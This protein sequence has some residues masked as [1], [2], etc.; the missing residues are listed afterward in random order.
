MPKA[1]P[2]YR[3]IAPFVIAAVISLAASPAGAA[4]AIPAALPAAAPEAVQN[5]IPTYVI[6]VGGDT[7]AEA[8]DRQYA[9]FPP[10]LQ[11][12]IPR[13]NISAYA[14][15]D[16]AAAAAQDNTDIIVLGGGTRIGGRVYPN[17][18]QMPGVLIEGKHHLRIFGMPGPIID[19]DAL[20]NS[21]GQKNEGMLPLVGFA[22]EEATGLV[23]RN[24]SNISIQDVFFD[25]AGLIVENTTGFWMGGGSIG[26]AVTLGAG[27]HGFTLANRLEMEGGIAIAPDATE[28]AL[29]Y[30]SLFLPQGGWPVAAASPDQLRLVHNHFFQRNAEGKWQETAPEAVVLRFGDEVMSLAEFQALKGE[31]RGADSM[32]RA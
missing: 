24:S 21:E 32:V 28:V 25:G 16:L 14:T 11:N 22:G 2:A 6:Y 9:E 13:A 7:A 20:R 19:M 10:E 8:L 3:K 1:H 29:G 5:Y 15:L 27:V 12:S 17:G 26:G 31:A 18:S 23:V 30:V 4:L